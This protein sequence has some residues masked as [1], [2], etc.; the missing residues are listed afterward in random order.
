MSRFKWVWLVAI[1]LVVG[2]CASTLT[3]D[4]KVRV[5]A[6]PQANLTAYKTYAWLGS[7]QIVHDPEGQWEPPQ[8]DADAELRFLIDA[9]LRKRGMTEVNR[10]P[11]MVVAFIAGIDMAAL[12]LEEDPKDEIKM[13]EKT[14]KGAL[15]LLFL[16]GMNGDTIWAASAIGDLKQKQISTEDVRTRLDYA[17]REMFKQLPAS[18]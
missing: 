11:D 3:E 14:P 18:G 10:N 12:N 5:E 1:V 4:I 8:F 15:V 9:Q 13:L 16:D 7:A 17:V 2:G 6:D